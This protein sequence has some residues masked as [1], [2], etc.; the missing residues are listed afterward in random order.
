M[1]KFQSLRRRWGWRAVLNVTQRAVSVTQRAVS[2]TQE[3]QPCGVGL[4]ALKH[5]YFA[6]L[7]AK[8]EWEQALLETD[9]RQAGGPSSRWAPPEKWAE[10]E[11]AAAAPAQA[12][13]LWPVMASNISAADPMWFSKRYQSNQVD[14][15]HVVGL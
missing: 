8:E 9:V 14:F 4:Q 1:K 11:E 12:R 3:A 5:P 13:Q 2:V 15:D 7:R 10:E 6:E